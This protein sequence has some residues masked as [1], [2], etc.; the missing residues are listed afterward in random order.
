LQNASA[1]NNVL[2]PYQNL[3]DFKFWYTKRMPFA[4]GL[5]PKPNNDRLRLFYNKGF[6]FTILVNIELI[7]NFIFNPL[8]ALWVIILV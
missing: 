2:R 5:H 1:L 8:V 4:F 7:V 3:I 6:P